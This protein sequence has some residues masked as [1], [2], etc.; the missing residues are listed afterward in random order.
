MTMAFY[1][2]RVI[3]E[4]TMENPTIDRGAYSQALQDRAFELLDLRLPT[5]PI[6]KKPSRIS[7]LQLVQMQTSVKASAAACLGILGQFRGAHTG[8]SQEAGTRKGQRLACSSR[9]R[10]CLPDRPPPKPRI[11][12]IL[13]NPM[14]TLSAMLAPTYNIRSQSRP[15][16]LPARAGCRPPM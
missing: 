9:N 13:R 10:F 1:A 7:P 11:L 4:P 6:G 12:S 15:A 3:R 5:I 16:R 14:G 2:G 8:T